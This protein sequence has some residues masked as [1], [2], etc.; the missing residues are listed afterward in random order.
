MNTDNSNAEGPK[1]AADPL[2]VRFGLRIPMRDG[3]TLH[4][5]LYLPR[6]GAGRFPAIITM[7]PY[8]IQTYH[9]FG[10]YF[11]TQGLP[12]L[13]VDCRGRGSS[14]G[15]FV[16]WRDD[17][18]D[19]H[20][21][22]EWVA[23]QPWCGGK[24]SMW[25]GSYAG[26]NQ[27][28]TAATRPPHLATIVPV[29]APYPGVDFPMRTNIGYCYISTWSIYTAGRAL[30][31]TL[32]EDDALWKTRWTQ[33]ARLGLPF[34]TLADEFGYKAPHLQ[35][36]LANPIQGPLYDAYNL[37]SEAYAA[38]DL[39]ILTITGHY[40]SDQTGALEHYRR[41]MA[42]APPA[43]TQHHYL[44]IGPWDHSGTRTPRPEIGDL[45]LGPTSMV[46]LP[47][48]H[49]D[50]Y[51]WTMANGERPGFLEDRIAY[52]VMGAE[53]W[54][55][56][57]SLEAVTA[58]HE[59]Y[60]LSSNGQAD[61][62]VRSGRLGCEAAHGDPDSYVYDPR[63]QSDTMCYMP[64]VMTPSQDDRRIWEQD[65]RHL[66]YHS[67]P[68]AESVEISGFF[69]FKGWIAID[70]PC[71]DFQVTVYEAT[72]DGRNIALAMDVMR[73]R[74]RESLREERFVETT[75]PMLYDLDRFNFTSREM[76]RGSRLRILIEPINFI[77]MQKNYNAP[78]PI[79]E[80][81]LA[82]ARTVT[83]RLFHDAAH[84]SALLV[85]IGQV[86]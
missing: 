43:V 57:P 53:C 31:Q 63:G 52:Y 4:A 62:I 28:V 13:A 1:D 6:E 7:T 76:A 71:T 23:A 54:R 74:H 56:A 44:V 25:G 21:T 77:G 50:W 2:D 3:A 86:R 59:T 81:T 42:L 5:A 69:R 85:P 79:N 84:P 32:F 83:V 70:Q 51:R 17:A 22:V 10:A 65:G 49:V 58:R 11:A 39:P 26:F 61:S 82:D 33:R 20:D 55:Y 38:L 64:M 30:Q 40:D 75:E 24:V 19:G 35:D 46:D 73:A 60:F 27:W 8:T 29:A 45:K 37:T 48:L 72:N 36:W 68:F 34:A 66:V 16:C 78:L 80:Q 12:F 18:R 9:S 41:H 14:D 47:A 15:E 67:A